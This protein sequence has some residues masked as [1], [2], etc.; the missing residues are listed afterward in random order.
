MVRTHSLIEHPMASR[1]IRHCDATAENFDS[2][3][4][5]DHR[6]EAMK[7]ILLAGV[8]ATFLAAT[9]AWVARSVMP[10]DQFQLAEG[11]GTVANAQSRLAEGNGSWANAQSRLA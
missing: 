10:G 11:N 3:F 9:P 6:N 1:C 2:P 5:L 7:T 4:G 8:A